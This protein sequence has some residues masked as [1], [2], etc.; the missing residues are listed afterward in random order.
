MPLVQNTFAF[1]V[2]LQLL[3]ICIYCTFSLTVH[4]YLL[5]IFIYC[6][7][8]F[9]VHF[10]LIYI[11]IEIKTIDAC[12]SDVDAMTVVHGISP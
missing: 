9:T 6:S 5:F 1:N 12:I 2:H 4:L 3:Y 10:N 11:C 8:S 7:F